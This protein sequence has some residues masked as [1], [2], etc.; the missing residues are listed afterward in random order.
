[1]PH[2][3]LEKKVVLITGGARGIGFATASQLHERG[4]SIAIVD[5]D[6]TEAEEAA[7]RVGE[8]AI[9]IGAD[10]TDEGAVM[11]A[12]AETVERLGGLDVAIANAGIAPPSTTTARKIP[13]EQ[14]QRVIDI[15]LLG[16]W[17]TARAALP[18]VVERGGQ[19]I[20]IGSIYSFAN[21]LLASPYAVSKA[22]VEALGR[23]LRVELAPLGASA[24]FVYFGWVETD[25]VRDSIDRRDDGFGARALSQVLPG[26]LLRRIPP[27]EA[28]IAIAQALEKRAPRTFAPKVWR[29]ISAFRG[30]LNPLLD[31]RFERDDSVASLV[32]EAEAN[33]DRRS[34][35]G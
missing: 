32:A 4:A 10:V 33:A 18:Q 13:P 31:R 11:A 5:L 8:R 12:V 22:G 20:F 14:F 15:N 3:D 35:A 24:G 23:A 34:A 21:G 2:Y 25:L 17:H 26:P 29:Y 28:G 16:A 6:A 27:E 1:V 30:L 19:V 7:E 9:G